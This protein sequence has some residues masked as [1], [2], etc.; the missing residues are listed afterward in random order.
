MIVFWSNTDITGTYVSH[1]SE[2]SFMAKVTVLV[3][4]YIGHQDKICD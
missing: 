4:F 2:L 3:T 1:W